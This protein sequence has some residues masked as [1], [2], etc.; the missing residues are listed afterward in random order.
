[1]LVHQADKYEGD[2]SGQEGEHAQD[3]G[4]WDDAEHIQSDIGKAGDS[5]GNSALS[6]GALPEQT[7]DEGG[8]AAGGTE[9][10]HLPQKIQDAG[11]LKGHESGNDAQ[12]QVDDKIALLQGLFRHVGVYHSAVNVVQHDGGESDQHSVDGRHDR[13]HD[14]GDQKG[15]GQR[16]QHFKGDLEK[17]RVGGVVIQDIAVH[18]DK[19]GHQGGGDHDDE[20]Q[21]QTPECDLLTFGGD[22]ALY[23]TLLTQSGQRNGDTGD[24]NGGDTGQPDVPVGAGDLTGLDSVIDNINGAL[25]DQDNCGDNQ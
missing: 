22:D 6:G 25:A 14:G 17:Y 21:N 5:A 3:G 4:G 15:G 12:T 2:G 8:E 18:A 9:V 20:G 13:G 7:A 19:S 23:G 10:V 11:K 24:E 16:I 1:M